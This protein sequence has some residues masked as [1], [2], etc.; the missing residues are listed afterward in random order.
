MMVYNDSRHETYIES[1]MTP[2]AAAHM[3]TVRAR[4]GRL[5]ALSVP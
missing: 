5:S 2:N 3:T 4:P 1:L